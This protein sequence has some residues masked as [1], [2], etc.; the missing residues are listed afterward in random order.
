MK[1]KELN[2]LMLRIQN[3][4]ELAFD[5]LY[6]E[7]HRGVF[8]FIYSMLN[9]FQNTEDVLQETYIKIKLNSGSYKIGT[10]VISWILQIAKNTALNYIKKDARHN[11][12]NIDEIPVLANEKE[13]NIED[14]FYLHNLLNKVLAEEDRHIFILHTLYGYKNKEIAKFLNLPLG[15]VLWKYNRAIKILKE[16]IKEDK[17]EQ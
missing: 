15:T 10:N 17:N 3:G 4:E 11:S 16:K 13:Y 6:E 1:N 8:S 9:N 14:S 5:I 7:T 2:S 12:V